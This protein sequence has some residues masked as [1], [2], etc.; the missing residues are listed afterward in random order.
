MKT[1]GILLAGGRGTRLYPNTKYINKHLMPM[2]DKPM[3]YYSLSI[4]LLSGIRNITLVCNTGESDT[5]KKLLGD[6]SEFGIRIIYAEQNSPDGIPDAISKAL[7]VERY[8][9]FLVVLGDNFI[10]GEKF[11]TRFENIFESSTN[12]SIFTQNV[13]N[14]E[15]FG[16][17]QLHEDKLISIVEKPQK[18]ISNKA[19]VGI[20]IFDD[21][22]QS[23]FSKLQKSKRNEYEIIDI[24]KSYGLNKINHT[25]IGRGTA[26][27][28]MGSA[29]DFLNCSYFIR[30]IQSRQGLLVCSPHE[31]SYRNNWITKKQLIDYINSI[32]NSE[33]SENLLKIVNES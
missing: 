22:F 29:D 18:F 31:I 26:W 4:F 15:L 21:N 17:A 13:N 12:A 6:G 5:F 24:L 3:I 2:Y 1:G 27:F 32:A 14:P 19:I 11:F 23:H 16:V 30:T 20:Y 33:Y 28:D 7:N 25:F 9:K 10:F 8:E